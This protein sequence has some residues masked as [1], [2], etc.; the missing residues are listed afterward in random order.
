MK[1]ISDISGPYVHGGIPGGLM[2][3]SD[4]K[5]LRRTLAQL[6]QEH[7]DLDEAILALEA[8]Q[9]RDQLRL[10]RLKKRKLGIKDEIA[11][12]EDQ[13]LPDIIA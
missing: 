12:L 7:R 4:D 13:L 5:Q 3:I 2:D 9:E 8:A 1:L 6:R 11:R 10:T